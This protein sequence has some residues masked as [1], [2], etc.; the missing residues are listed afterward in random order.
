MGNEHS[1]QGMSSK[2]KA[3]FKQVRFHNDNN[4]DQKIS[5]HVLEP[6]S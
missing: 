3:L 2:I 1:F 5:Y 6:K 4:N